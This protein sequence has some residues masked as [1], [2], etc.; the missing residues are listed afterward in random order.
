MTTN[1]LV[2]SGPETAMGG[3]ICLYSSLV[4]ARA[5]RADRQ[6]DDSAREAGRSHIC[7]S[8]AP[9]IKNNRDRARLYRW[10]T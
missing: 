6:R 1:A 5:D 3:V 7:C 4:A 2:S 8:P 10:S 9:S